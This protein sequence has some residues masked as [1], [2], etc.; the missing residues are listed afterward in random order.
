M[1]VSKSETSPNPKNQI[2]FPSAV[3]AGFIFY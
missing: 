2:I 3:H 1:F